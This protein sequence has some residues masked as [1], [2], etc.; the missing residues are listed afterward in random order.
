MK[1]YVYAV[2]TNKRA[3]HI[4]QA[5]HQ[6]LQKCGVQAVITNRFDGVKADIAIAYGWVHEDIFNAYKAEG[7]HYAYWDL[8]YIERA[9]LEGYH[10]LA[11]DSWDTA[12]NM[13]RGCSDD[14][15]NRLGVQLKPW[16]NNSR[17]NDL[18]VI[19]MSSKAAIT[20][21]F[22]FGEW[23]RRIV[24]SLHS[25]EYPFGIKIR[26]KP[27]RE[28]RHQPSIE[29]A[30]RHAHMAIMHHSNVAI[31]AVIAGV[32]VYAEKGVGRIVSN[33]LTSMDICK[34]L[35]LSDMRR[36]QFLADVAYA[37]YSV[38]EMR[39]GTVWQCIREIINQ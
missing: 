19:G 23:E 3:V 38:P 17:A 9:G 31:D 25:V 28:V 37:Q 13:L 15:I 29:H 35:V 5:M 24:Q 10:R 12:D 18:L 6:G 30:L 26:P 27:N 22:D 14:R 1:A 36:M 16:R 8:G 7:A 20:H 21:G 39:D 2:G 4:A 11:V 33:G 34:P 32:P